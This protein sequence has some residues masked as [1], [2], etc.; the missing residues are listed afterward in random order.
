MTKNT[1]FGTFRKES[2]GGRYAWLPIAIIMAI[3]AVLFTFRL[4]A[5]GVWIDELFSIQDASLDSLWEVYRKSQLRPLYYILLSF[6]MRFGQSDV[7]L[8]SLSVIFSVISVFL[9]YRL[10]R[11]LAGKTEGLI[12]AV[13]L[14]TS[15]LFI[16]HTQ[17][18]RMYGL[19]LC[20]GLAGSLFLAEA[21]LTESS[22]KPGQKTLGGWALFRLLAMCTV[23]LNVMLLLPDTLLIFLRFRR[24]RSVLLS[25]AKWLVLVFILWTPALL[26]AFQNVVGSSDYA[27]ERAKFAEA[28]GI[29][30]LVYPLKFWMVYPFVVKGRPV[31]HIFYKLFT[32]LIAGLVGAGLIRRRQ[33]PALPWASAWFILP[34]VPIIVLS[35]VAARLWEP[36]YVLFV[37]PYLFILMAAGFTRLWRDWKKAAV[38]ITVIYAIGMGGAL[39]DYYT[40]QNRA[41]Y[42]FNI[43][44][45]EQYE[46]PGDAVVWG[47]PWKNALDHYYDG[48]SDIFL[49]SERKDDAP[50]ET[51]S[52]PEEIEQWVNKFPSQPSRTWLVVEKFK[53]E[54]A[55][56]LEPILSKTYN[57]E[58]RFDYNHNS[59]IFLLT[60]LET[61]SKN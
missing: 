14:M 57:I 42:K 59:A 45:I 36:R 50:T 56:E 4:G 10:G 49:I 60:P 48:S 17:E 9:I 20:L 61:A 22:D 26:P 2:A 6:W 30:N 32:L 23:P 27:Q 34:I 15:P 46:E 43:E 38:V 7:W 54:L 33:L 47:Y 19:S 28:P 52:T 35:L 5:E 21:L 29:N 11:R 40:A 44:T 24:E 16:N 53:S 8:R 18:I 31:A 12:A 41:D 37:S 51:I 25:F 3:S 13:L 58:E 39:A 55:E 1:T